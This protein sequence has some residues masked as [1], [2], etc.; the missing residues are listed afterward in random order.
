MS[1]Y[2]KA[3]ETRSTQVCLFADSGKI[4][5]AEGTTPVAIEFAQRDPPGG[6][7]LHMMDC[8]RDPPKPMEPSMALPAN[9]TAMY[10]VAVR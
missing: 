8:R 2:A 4:L 9:N 7:G 5:R 3:Y 1:Q 10:S 6:G